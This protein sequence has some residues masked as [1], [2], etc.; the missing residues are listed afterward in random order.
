MTPAPSLRLPD[1]E[2]M[3]FFALCEL[4]CV[5]SSGESVC[6]VCVPVIAVDPRIVVPGAEV[7]VLALPTYLTRTTATE[8]L[9]NTNTG[10]SITISTLR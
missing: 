5:S 9:G 4:C 8:Q 3:L 10:K 6:I 1:L 7:R 2:S